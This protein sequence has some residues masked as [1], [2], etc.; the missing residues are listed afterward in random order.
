LG[1]LYA[2]ERLAQDNP[3]QRQIIVNVLCAYLRMPYTLPRTGGRQRPLGI[4]RPMLRTTRPATGARPARLTSVDRDSAATQEREVRLAAQRILAEH[5][6]VLPVPRSDVPDPALDSHWADID[7]DL[8][9]ATLIE[10]DLTD[11][12]V[13]IANFTHATFTGDTWF[14]GARFS[15]TADFSGAQFSDVAWFR[16]ARFNRLVKFNEARF[17]N[18]AYFSKVRFRFIAEFRE[19]Q[20]SDFADFSKARFSSLTD[21]IET[22]FSGDAKFSRARFSNK[23]WFWKARFSGEAKFSRARFSSIADFR[24]AQFSGDTKFVGAQF[25]GSVDF[26]AAALPVTRYL[27]ESTPSP[28]TDFAKAQFAR[29]VPADLAPFVMAPDGAVEESLSLN[30]TQT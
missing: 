7:I 26:S 13:N 28:W 16:G 17:S 4:A 11:C 8:T 21:F 10:F 14:G 9:G 19:A 27:G 23:A 30:R 18:H 12:D 2:L 29:E 6:H 20:F 24:A 1:G 22:R 15:G 5:F 3:G 25:D